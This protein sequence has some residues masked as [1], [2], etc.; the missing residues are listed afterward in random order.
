MDNRLTLPIVF[1]GGVELA[2]H[3]L[4]AMCEARSI[5][6]LAIGY[7]ETLSD[8]S[9][10]ASLCPTCDAWNIPL[11]ETEDINADEVRAE[12]RASGAQAILVVAWS[13][14]LKA[15]T[16]HAVPH[17][18]FGL[19]PTLLPE[20][21]GRAPIPWSL[22]KGLRQTGVTLFRLNEG[23]DNGDVI[24]QRA[25]E[26]SRHDD[27]RTVYA[28]AEAASLALLLD[29]IEAISTGRVHPRPQE[30]ESSTWPK[31]T[32]GDGEITWSNPG[33]SVYDWIRG[34]TRPYP[35]AFTRLRDGRLVH[36]WSADLVEAGGKAIGEPGEVL[37]LS[38]RAGGAQEGG[39]VVAAGT[40]LLIL[41]EVEP[42]GDGSIDALAAADNGL[43]SVGDRLG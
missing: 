30:G 1:V 7:P 32:P 27:A 24:D 19:H 42:E 37:G 38:L 9:G 15:D 40:D 17:G 26:I 2:R 20:G 8:R 25:F 43:F 12:I 10:Y 21:R 13:Q 28:K 29:N 22:I 14:L 35:G 23:V 18:A 36:V 31:R 16:L 5:P 33:R 3:C 11:I 4:Q 6:A 41:R 39:V 34:L